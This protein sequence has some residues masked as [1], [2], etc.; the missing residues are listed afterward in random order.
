MPDVT[1][2][3]PFIDKVL[4]LI[5]I[6]SK[7]IL[8]VGCGRGLV[9]AICK[10]YRHADAI[11]G[12]DVFGDYLEFC[13]Q[14]MLYD[15]LIKRD[16]SQGLP[17]LEKTFDVGVCLEVIEHMEKSRGRSLLIEMEKVCRRVIVS[18][19]ARFHQQTAYDNNPHQ[20]HV[21]AWSEKQFTDMGFT[22]RSGRSRGIWILGR[23]IKYLS[24]GLS[25][26]LSEAPR[27]EWILAYKDSTSL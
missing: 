20:I 10:I 22:I 9:G 13:R 17:N 21:S 25:K 5:P 2:T 26:F 11:W 24:S 23:S 4:D 18:T 6:D 8:D 15:K 7:N 19:P 27:E 16:L 14:H 3:H 12:I 1:W